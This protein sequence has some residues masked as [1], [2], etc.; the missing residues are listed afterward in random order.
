MTGGWPD[1]DRACPGGHLSSPNAFTPWRSCFDVV[2]TTD[3][4]QIVDRRTVTPVAAEHHHGLEGELRPRRSHHV[5]AEQS[6][7]ARRRTPRACGATPSRSRQV[8]RVERSCGSGGSGA[9]GGRPSGACDPLR[10]KSC[11]RVHRAT[12]GS[13]KKSCRTAWY[14]LYKLVGLAGC[15]RNPLV[16]AVD[17]LELLVIALAILVGLFAVAGAGALG[18]QS[19]MRRSATA[20]ATTATAAGASIET[21][22]RPDGGLASARHKVIRSHN[23]LIRRWFGT[24]AVGVEWMRPTRPARRLSRR[25]ALRA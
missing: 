12:P 6:P 22:V 3:E 25:S 10:N 14:H 19:Q 7:P 15:G 20:T 13:L 24:S 2:A 16:R 1:L 17:R 18:A 5:T 8:S 11:E 21:R 9:Y 4:Q 23:G